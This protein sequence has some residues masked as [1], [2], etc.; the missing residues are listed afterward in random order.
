MKSFQNPKLEVKKKKS[1]NQPILVENLFHICCSM[2]WFVLERLI[3]IV[4]PNNQL[5]HKHEGSYNLEVF[6]VS[7]RF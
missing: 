1:D 4:F 7:V 5:I 2:T 3:P 6:N